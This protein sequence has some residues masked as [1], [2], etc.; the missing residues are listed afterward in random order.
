MLFEPRK[1]RRGQRSR[2][3]LRFTDEADAATR[4]TDQVDLMSAVGAPPC[5]DGV[6]AALPLRAAG[7]SR[8][9]TLQDPEPCQALERT[10]DRHAG[11]VGDLAPSRLADRD[12]LKDPE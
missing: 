5:G 1:D 9:A 8:D 4:D 11:I 6:G 2:G 7:E 12:G 3:P 10:F